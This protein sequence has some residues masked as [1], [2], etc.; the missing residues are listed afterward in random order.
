M[1]K[2][3]AEEDGPSFEQQFGILANAVITEKFP[4]LDS[5]KIAF[6]LIEKKDDDNSAVGAMVYTVGS[7]VVFVPAFYKG[8]KIKTGDMMFL[9]QTQQFL[10]LA[11]PWLAYI[12]D[13]DVSPSGEIVSAELGTHTTRPGETRMFEY[14]NPIIKSAS[15]YLKGLLHTCPDLS[16]G[17]SGS[18]LDQV[19]MMG[20]EASANLCGELAGDTMFLNAA[21]RFYSG[22]ELDGFCKSAA[23]M[24]EEPEGLTLVFP[25]TKEAAALTPEQQTVLQR[26]GYFIKHAAESDVAVIEKPQ[27]KS[28]FGTVPGPC[29]AQV[30]DMNGDM[31]KCVLLRKLD[32]FDLCSNPLCSISAPN[33][34]QS[35]KEYMG[36]GCRDLIV[37]RG[38][39]VD[40]IP[41]D[42]MVLA[43]SVEKLDGDVLSSIGSSLKDSAPEK[44]TWDTWLVFP[45]GSAVNG[46][47][48][49]FRLCRDGECSWGLGNGKALCIGESD[50]QVS[51]IEM[52]NAVI[53]PSRTRWFEQD[54]RKPE[55]DVRSE[56]GFDGPVKEPAPVRLLPVTTGSLDAF[57]RNYTAKKYDKVR[58][59][60][61]GTELEVSGDKTASTVRGGAGEAAFELV[62]HYGIDSDIARL[63]LKQASEGAAYDAP[64]AKVYY[65]EKAA[66]AMDGE[67][68][69]SNLGM[70]VSEKKE[71]QVDKLEM[72]EGT[73]NPEELKK[74]VQNAAQNG[75]KEVF[76]VTAL[77]LLVK[78]T[79]FFDDIS[80]DMP[81]FM[82]T[83]DSLCRKLFQFYWH[84]DKMEAK[85]GMSKLKTLE[86]SL[87]STLDS[88][89]ELTIFFKL[90]TVDGTG[91]TGDTAGDLISGNMLG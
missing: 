63:M 12:K 14:S 76:D 81:L 57:I 66:G 85:Y 75:I 42:T 30:L 19:F 52:D 83:L 23:M 71:P 86:E 20:K 46:Y 36:I 41:G 39:T 27:V 61:N 26:D 21:L 32:R 8:S 84:T 55:S 73:G 65:I 67:W 48:A 31:E 62:S 70:S 3:A 79:R 49:E 1:F 35:S 11:D 72:P 56:Q 34:E 51:P 69:D 10:P 22:D 25:F 53:L 15:V 80:E 89:S 82:R 91:S 47:Q 24:C 2:S 77:K 59:Y 28:M 5:M 13:K 54:M 7:S 17:D 33:T 40:H 29:R 43:S 16:A 18:L 38:S 37:V 78:Q 90:R 88:L 45:D 4:Q 68:P 9:A 64:K 6:Q 74:A 60:S 50:S 87:K 44:I 58:V